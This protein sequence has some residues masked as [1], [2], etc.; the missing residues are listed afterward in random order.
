MVVRFMNLLRRGPVY[1]K[2]TASTVLDC[3][4]SAK[5]ELDAYKRSRQ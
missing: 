2:E 4:N 5:Q 3:R 1:Q